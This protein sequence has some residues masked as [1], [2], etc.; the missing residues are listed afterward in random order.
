MFKLYIYLVQKYYESLNIPNKQLN[1]YIGVN[2]LPFY[3][4]KWL[5]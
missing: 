2:M 1:V 3:H 4:S 5:Y